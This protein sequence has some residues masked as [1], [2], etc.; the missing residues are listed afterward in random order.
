MTFSIVDFYMLKDERLC[1]ASLKSREDQ[2]HII[3]Y[4]RQ[5]D[6]LPP[7]EVQ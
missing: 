5:Y 6:S 4:S 1:I 3:H 7:Q 2:G